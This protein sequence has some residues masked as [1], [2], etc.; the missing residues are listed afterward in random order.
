MLTEILYQIK[1]LIFYLVLLSI[2]PAIVLAQMEDESIT[3]QL[4]Y[5]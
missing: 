1:Q 5:F 3:K 4:N 2:C